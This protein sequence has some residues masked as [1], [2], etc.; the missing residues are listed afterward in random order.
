ME[1]IKRFTAIVC[2][3]ISVCVLFSS[4]TASDRY[5]TGSLV[6]NTVADNKFHTDSENYETAA[7]NGFIEM[8]VDK[9]NHSL[10]V[11]DTV[12]GQKWSALPEN[13]NSS[14]YAFGLVLYTKNGCYSLNTQDNSVAFSASEYIVEDKKITVKYTLSN[15]KETAQKAYDEM[16]ADDIFV[17]FSVTYELSEQS[18]YMSI[19]LSDM[20]C[21]KNSFVSHI[22]IMPCFGAGYNDTAD[23]WFLV[24]DNS[25][26]VMYLDKNEAATDSIAINIYGE[27]QY[28]ANGD[29]Y[30]AAILPVYGVKRGNSAFAAVITDGDALAQIKA[31]RKNGTEPSKIYPDFT[32][33][34]I[35]HS[36]ETS[37]RKGKSYDGKI[38]VVYKF[39]SD[40]N[41][42]YTSM[43]SAAREEFIKSSRLSSAK[44][45]ADGSIPFS[46]TIVGAEA[47]ELLTTTN[48]TTDILGILKGKGISNIVLSCKGMYTGGLS[49][50]NIYS[51]S[52]NNKLGGKNGIKGLH[53]YTAT[54]DCTLLLG[55][56]ILSSGKNLLPDDKSYTITSDAARYEMKNDLG[57]NENAL[58]GLLTRIGNDAFSLGKEKAT[59]SIYSETAYY[60]MNLM[61]ITSFKENFRAFLDSEILSSADG[62]AVTD[63]GRVLYSDG[64]TTRQDA[65]NEVSSMLKAV[66]NYGELSVEGG[67]LYSLYNAELITDMSFDTYYPESEYYEAVPFAQAVL[68]GSVLYTGTAIDAGNP[69]YRYDM[70]RYIE[71]GAV[72]SY[73]WIYENAN[74][75]C[76]NG[77]L[78]S[79]R[80]SETVD[81]YSDAVSMLSEL[82]DDTIVNHKKIT[83]DSQGNSVSGVYCT[84]Y[85]DGTEI[86]V[87]YTGSIV[88][89]SENIA[90]G[91]YDYVKVKR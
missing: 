16:T 87:N 21:T 62:I 25:G 29:A 68:H 80:I 26:A 30:A 56:N 74:I 81:F 76:Y 89:T 27:D 59:P 24:P 13:S 67:N 52:I 37:L 11:K 83:L 64:K 45:D 34:E 19:D 91:P 88:S 58:S 23:D 71:Y 79:E 66:S 44:T 72:P 77:Y 55:V 5:N 46:L 10:T 70:L 4:C 47:S 39:L 53:E 63:A 49:Q 18:V 73:K 1:R 75:Y 60:E 38:T 9:L 14:A 33:T 41:A 15:K 57:Y 20:K 42:T 50:S 2:A 48:Q 28:N 31:G 43:A 12:T 40:N 51:S 17:I 78:L 69:L 36:K 86:Y 22:S 54:Q 65:M 61:N 7:K 35:L 8:C 6:E 32:V 85:S 3:V 82:A 84:E 90:V